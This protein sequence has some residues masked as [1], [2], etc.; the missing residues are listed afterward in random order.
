MT[1]ANDPD[2]VKLMAWSTT[3]RVSLS[4]PDTVA[5]KDEVTREL[6]SRSAN[7]SCLVW[8]LAILL[9]GRRT[10]L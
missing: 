1:V 9:S 8:T 4:D 5:L 7:D 3:P 2:P 10:D 6:P